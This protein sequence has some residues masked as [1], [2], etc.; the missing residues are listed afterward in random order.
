MVGFLL[1]LHYFYIKKFSFFEKICW[2]SSLQDRLLSNSRNE[3]TTSL[4]DGLRSSSRD[5]KSKM[6]QKQE[7]RWIFISFFYN[8]FA[9]ISLISNSKIP[10]GVS[11]L[12]W[13]PTFLPKIAWP[14]GD[15][16]LIKPWR[17]LLS[18]EPTI[19]YFTSSSNVLS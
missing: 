10:F 7:S 16:L 9:E 18:V 17:G 15:S 8:Y 12:T 14:T 3:I 2:C 19:L 4:Q 13:S 11:T 6:D 1:F 5:D